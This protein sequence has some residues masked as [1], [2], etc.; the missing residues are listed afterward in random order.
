M[1]YC[2]FQGGVIN[3]LFG[4]KEELQKI[5]LK[6]KNLNDKKNKLIKDIRILE[7]QEKTERYELLEI[8]LK[9]KG[10]TLSEL[11]EKLNKQNL[12]MKRISSFFV[13]QF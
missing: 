13:V 9:E 8:S 2:F 7:M 12:R 1:Q 5:E 6:I 11:M 10:I 3:K 4:K